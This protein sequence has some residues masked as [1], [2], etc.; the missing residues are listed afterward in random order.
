MGHNAHFEVTLLSLEERGGR[1]KQRGDC[2]RLETRVQRHLAWIRLF[3]DDM[4]L[5]SEPFRLHL[6]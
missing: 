6:P 1:S 5:A 2:R 4:S 3:R